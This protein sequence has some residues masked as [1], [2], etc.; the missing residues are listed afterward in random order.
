VALLAAL[1]H[2]L[3]QQAAL[4]APSFEA[5][6]TAPVPA[7]RLHGS[8]SVGFAGREFLL[9]GALGTEAWTRVLPGS[10]WDPLELA[11]AIG[12]DALAVPQP[13]GILLFGGRDA[14]DAPRS[15]DALRLSSAGASWALVPAIAPVMPSGESL[16]LA[17]LPRR[18]GTAGL[19]LLSRIE[20][21]GT[22]LWHADAQGAQ[23]QLR[24]RAPQS[25]QRPWLLPFGPAHLLAGDRDGVEVFAWHALT[26]TWVAAGELPA[27]PGDSPMRLIPHRAPGTASLG[28]ADGCI[29]LAYLVVVLLIGTRFARREKQSED[30][31]IAGRRIPAWAAGCSILAT[32]ISAITFLSTPAVAFA[33]DWSLLPSWFGML[34]FAPVAVF[35]FLPLFRK[36]RAP[37]AYSWLEDR[38]GLPVRQFG[39]ASFLIFQIARMGV[40]TYLPAL[41]IAHATGLPHQACILI[42]GAIAILYTVLGGMEAVIWTDVL[43]TFAIFGGATAAIIVLVVGAGGPTEVWSAVSEAGKTRA[44]NP[45]WSAF[46]DAGWLV[47]IGGWFLQFGPYSA[48]Q[49]IVQ[50]YLSTPDEKSAARAIWMNGWLSAPVGLLFLVVGAGLWAWFRAHPER[51][52]IGMANDEVFPIFLMQGLPPGVGGLIL[53]ALAA[54]AMSTLDSGMHACATVLTHDFWLRLRREPPEDAVILRVARRFAVAAG[55]LGTGIALALAAGEVRSLLLFF[56]KVLGLV[57]SGVAGVFTLGVLVRRAGTAA[58][59]SG[60]AACTLLLAGLAF[61]TRVNLFLYPLAGIPTCVAVGWLVSRWAP[62]E[63]AA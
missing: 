15:H 43:Q 52:E 2:L 50:R 12:W 46:T 27:A 44:W 56:L 42:C 54:A 38:F 25:L 57:M 24:A 26:D 16:A 34:L 13:D 4:Q 10:A 45:S 55:L 9:G 6:V 20:G 14:P 32:Q 28:L 47:L 48:D 33:T 41:A 17:P 5:D 51:L 35:V 18:D 59:L 49:A 1:I 53:A 22:E 61:A 31:F 62:R 37:T 39:A 19:V 36:L 30:W 11:E 29:L 3:T 7:E 40:V 60:A 63:T 8:V 21:G 23:W 58:A